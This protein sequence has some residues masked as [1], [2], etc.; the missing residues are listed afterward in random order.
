MWYVKLPLVDFSADANTYYIQI[1]E[2]Y[3]YNIMHIS[4]RL[5]FHKWNIKVFYIS[6][7]RDRTASQTLHNKM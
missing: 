4:K 1:N 3:Y 2:K 6:L 5:Y 7:P